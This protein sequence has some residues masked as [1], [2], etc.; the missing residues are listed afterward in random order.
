MAVDANYS[1]IVMDLLSLTFDKRNFIIYTFFY[2]SCNKNYKKTSQSAKL[3]NTSQ[4]VNMSCLFVYHPCCWH[5]SE[6]QDLVDPIP[7]VT[8]PR[9]NSGLI[10]LGAS[11]APTDDPGEHEAIIPPLHDH[12]AAAIA[13]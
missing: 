7:E 5:F 6:L 9:V 13:L 11:D 1:R 2:F 8:Y 12:R 4:Q 3:K 10:L